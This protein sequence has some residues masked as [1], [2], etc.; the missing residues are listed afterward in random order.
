MTPSGIQKMKDLRWVEMSSL[1]WFLLHEP[2]EALD[3]DRMVLSRISGLTLRNIVG[4][5]A[6]LSD[7][8]TS[9]GYISATTR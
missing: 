3:W 5:L 9:T 2:P 6:T 4:E 1:A 7:A 8:A